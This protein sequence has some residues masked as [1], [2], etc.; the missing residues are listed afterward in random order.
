[1]SLREYQRDAAEKL[2]P[3]RVGALFMDMGT[4]KTRTATEIARRR[5][6]RVDRVVWLCPVSVR[7]E[8]QGM[9]E[10]HTRCAPGAIALFDHQSQWNDLAKWLIVGIETI[11]ASDAAYLALNPLVTPDTF[12]I[13]DES[14]MIKS[15]S[16]KRTQRIQRLGE[17]AKYRLILSGTPTPLGIVDL[18]TQMRFLS[19]KILGYKSFW[20]FAKNHLEFSPHIPGKVVRAHNTAYIAA[21]IAPYVY[22]AKL[23]DVEPLPT[24]TDHDVWFSMSEAQREAYDQVKQDL[25]LGL[26]SLDDLK[27][28]AILRLFT[29]LQQVTSGFLPREKQTDLLSNARADA[30]ASLTRRLPAAHT[31]IWCKYLRDMSAIQYALP[32]VVCIDSRTPR[33]ARAEA[34]RDFTSNGGCMALTY[35]C[36]ALGFTFNKATRT[37]LYSSVFDYAL[38]EQAKARNYRIGQTLPVTCYTLRCAN[39][40]DNRIEKNIQGKI[41]VIEQFKQ[42]LRHVRDLRTAIEEL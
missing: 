17:R 42:H 41:T 37:I 19:P 8:I 2:T 26:N 39:S 18:Y 33:P 6:A 27:D 38:T 30:L 20:A 36:A 16:A 28:Q 3:L 22:E 23:T 4:G 14:Q 31:L 12:L 15:P 9:I 35:G 5:L 24:Y 11:G 1:M 21:K 13:V 29:R 34:F 10:D 40:I 7:S 32:G 25:L